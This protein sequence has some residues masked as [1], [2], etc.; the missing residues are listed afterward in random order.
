MAQLAFNL[1]RGLGALAGSVLGLFWSYAMWIPEAGL[2][3]LSGVGFAVALLMC[4]LAIIAV[5]ASVRGHSGMLMVAFL[6]SFLPVGAVLLQVELWFRWIGVLDLLLLAGAALL[7][8]ASRHST[9]IER[10]GWT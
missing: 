3:S 9:A 8:F 4:F 10:D 7:W 1:G 5:I 6:A 2:R